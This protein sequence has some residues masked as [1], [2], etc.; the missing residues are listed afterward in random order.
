MSDVFCVLC[1]YLGSNLAIW[2]EAL[3]EESQ[4]LSLHCAHTATQ[5]IADYDKINTNISSLDQLCWDLD[6]IIGD[7][8]ARGDF[9]S[10]SHVNQHLGMFIVTWWLQ[11]RPVCLETWISMGSHVTLDQTS[12]TKNRAHRGRQTAI[13]TGARSTVFSTFETNHQ[14]MC[15]MQTRFLSRHRNDSCF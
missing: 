12:S 5:S 11:A 14:T 6:P 10:M 9:A 8:C 15:V 1:I 4:C 3:S 2:H 13:K 7:F